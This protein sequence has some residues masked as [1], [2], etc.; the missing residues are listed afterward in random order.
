MEPREKYVN[1]FTDFGFK[2]L[3]GEKPSKPLLLDFLNELLIEQEG[4]IKNITYLNTEHL[5]SSPLDRRAI[6]D[7]YCENERGEKF[8]VELQKAKQT[9]F[10]DRTLFYATF[11]IQEQAKQ[12]DWDFKLKAVYTVAILDFVFEE[13]K[14]DIHK[15]RYDVKLT[16]IETCKVFYDKLTFIYLELPKFNKKIDELSTNFEKWL[17]VLKNLHKLDKIPDQLKDKRFEKL[18]AIAEVA[19][20]TREELKSYEDSKKFYRDIKNSMDTAFEEGKEEGKEEGHKQGKIE[21]I[22]KGKAAGLKEGKLKGMNLGMKAGNIEGKKA[23]I[24]EIIRKGIS[25]NMSV[26]TL[27]QLTGLTENEVLDIISTLGNDDK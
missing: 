8:I 3:F 11:P 7:I 26:E 4:P 10:K 15:Y 19:H 20:F 13:D 1:I 6:F 22:K 27:T 18:F 25:N 9:Y 2:K 23:K 14:A 21:G 12:N 16:D 17:F 24:I 5:G